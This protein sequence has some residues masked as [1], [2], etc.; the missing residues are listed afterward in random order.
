MITSILTSVKKVLGIAEDYIAFDE[1]IIL[2]I[3]SVFS[4]LNQLGIGPEAGFAIS[5]ATATWA[6]F[7]GTDLLLN[8]VKTYMCLRVRMIFD[9][10]NT[11]YVMDAMQRQ[12]TELEWRLNTVREGRAWALPAS[13]PLRDEEII[14]GG[15]PYN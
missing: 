10:P 8:S 9:P 15:S 3:N 4:T 5:D 7:L 14:D 1:D 6:D 2:H 12:I 11:S 13:S